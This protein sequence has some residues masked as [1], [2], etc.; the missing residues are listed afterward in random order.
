MIK[1]EIMRPEITG[2]Q[3]QS[4]QSSFERLTYTVEEAA[5]I[6]GISRALAYRKG[7]LPTVQIAG[8]RLVPRQAL[9]KMLAQTG[10][11]PPS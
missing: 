5:E 9:A 3:K 1:G 7:V 10:V 11:I 8:R 2:V 6:L 4:R